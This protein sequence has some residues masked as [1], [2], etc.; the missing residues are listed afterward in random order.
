MVQMKQKEHPEQ[1]RP[2]S[3]LSDDE[4]LAPRKGIDRD[5][6]VATLRGLKSDVAPG[7]GCLRNKHLLALNLNPQAQP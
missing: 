7:L 4:K 3:P 1:K 5:V 6:F 2:I